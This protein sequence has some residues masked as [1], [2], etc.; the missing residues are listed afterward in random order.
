MPVLA[1]MIYLIGQTGP[2]TWELWLFG[3]VVAARYAHA[4][5]MVLSKSLDDIQPLRMI[6]SLGTYVGGLVLG[7]D[8]LLKTL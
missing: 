5:G 2:A 7:I 6:G 4:A 3:I 8:L 1:L